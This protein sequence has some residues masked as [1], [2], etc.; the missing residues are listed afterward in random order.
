MRNFAEAL[1]YQVD[2]DSVGRLDDEA[3]VNG[4]AQISPFDPAS[5]QALLEANTLGDRAELLTQLMLLHRHGDSDGAP[6]FQ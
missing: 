5:K 6:R 1:G 4:V 3:F 2:W